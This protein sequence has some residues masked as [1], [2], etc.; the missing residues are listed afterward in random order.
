MF[1]IPHVLGWLVFSAVAGIFV[2]KFDLAIS[3]AP[4]DV[5]SWVTALY[6]SQFAI[7]SSFGVVQLVESV[8]IFRA[9]SARCP[10]IAIAAEFA[11]TGLSLTAKSVLAWV[12]FA[13]LLA[14]KNISYGDGSNYNKAQ[15]IFSQNGT[16]V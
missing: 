15:R 13:N 9:P 10:R 16:D 7:M 4:N 11:Y 3:N 1:F 12:L 2:V 8:L 6:A 5:P 14:E